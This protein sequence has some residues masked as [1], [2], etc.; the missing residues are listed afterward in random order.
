MV[1]D[2]VKKGAK[3]VGKYVLNNP[4]NAMAI[5]SKA[6]SMAKF[7]ASVVNVE[8]KF[9]DTVFARTA[10]YSTPSISFIT[11]T[12]QGDAQSGSRNGDSI[13]LSS[14]NLRGMVTVPTGTAQ[15][16]RIV[17]IILIND[18][19]SDGSAP[20]LSDILDNS[21]LPNVYARYNPDNAGARFKI[22]YDKRIVVSA[23]TNAI[24]F[25]CYRKLRHHLKY[26]GSTANQSDASTGHL[27]VL[28]VSDDNAAGTDDPSVEWNSCIRY[29][30]N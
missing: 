8:H 17:R 14:V 4:G 30:D 13:K 25:G 18:K 24:K 2:K 22:M 6:L 3:K 12:S 23:T 7:L 5:A 28:V 21:T 29:I 26:T 15:T 19:V 11:G 10:I 20:A 9:K 16:P 1:L 27:Y